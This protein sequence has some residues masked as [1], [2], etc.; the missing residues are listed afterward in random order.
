MCA[1]RNVGWGGGAQRNGSENI[2]LLRGL[3]VRISTLGRIR[4][5]FLTSDPTPQTKHGIVAARLCHYGT[6]TEKTGARAARLCHSSTTTE[7]TGRGQPVSGTLVQPQRRWGRGY[8]RH[9]RDIREMKN[10]DLSKKFFLL[11]VNEL[12]NIFNQRKK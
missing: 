6:T 1:K 4:P 8:Q 7:K 2:P 9:R 3:S 10:I 12:Y 5:R 11:Q